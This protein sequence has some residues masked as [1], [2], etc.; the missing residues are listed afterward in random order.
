MPKAK[1]DWPLTSAALAKFLAHLDP[2]PSAAEEKFAALH[3]RLAKY[4]ELNRCTDPEHAADVTID[5]GIRK[6]DQGAT[7]PGIGA[8]L[9]GIA[10]FVLKELRASM[11]AAQPLPPDIAAVESQDIF[12]LELHVRCLDTCLVK[13]EPDSRDLFLLYYGEGTR[14]SLPDRYNSTM[15]ALRIRVFKVKKILHQCVNNCAT[16]RTA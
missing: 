10:R 1:Q 9:F 13:L 8:F 16:G 5:R 6:I 14:E 12:E 2:N 3:G 7:V 11:P 4:F 15:N